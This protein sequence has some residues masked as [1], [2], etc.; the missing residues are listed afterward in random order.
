MP[1]VISHAVVAVA[2]AAPFPEKVVTKR[3][4][5]LGAIGSMLPD[6]DVV[7]FRLGIKYEDILGHRGFTH[8]LLF[9]GV[10]AVVLTMLV[11]HSKRHWLWLYLFLATASHGVL[12]ALT[13]GGL[14][15]GFFSPFDPTRY[16]FSA[17]PIEVSP[18]GSGFFSDRGLKVVVS[19]L[20]W[21]WLPAL[22]FATLLIVLRKYLTT[23]CEV[24]D[25]SKDRQ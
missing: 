5:W 23:S 20:L 11:P 3:V 14:G 18:I 21:L 25:S 4:L 7:A 17:R 19:E 16:F 15:I 9:A 24:P 6:L 10:A 2:L 8:S 1:T 13:N 12:D 22:L